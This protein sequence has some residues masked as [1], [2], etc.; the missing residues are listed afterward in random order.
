MQLTIES[1]PC[2]LKAFRER[3]G[4]SQK[5]VIDDEPRY[6]TLFRKAATP[7]KPRDINTWAEQ[8]VTLFE[9]P[10][11]DR[12]YK[13]SYA[14]FAAIVLETLATAAGK[15]SQI[16]VIGPAQSGKTLLVDGIYPAYRLMELKRD[17]AIGA[18]TV[19]YA[20]RVWDRKLGP[21]ILNTKYKKHLPKIGSGSK[22]G[23][24]ESLQFLHGPWLKLFGA[25]GGDEQRSGDTVPCVTITETDKMDMPGEVSREADPVTQIIAR[26]QAFGEQGL[27]ILECT[28]STEEGRI[29][30]EAVINGSDGRF[31]IKCPHCF[32]WICP[33]RDHFIVDKKAKNAQEAAKS[34]FYACNECGVEWDE[35]DRTEANQYPRLVHNGQPID[36]AGGKREPG[37]SVNKKG[38]VVGTDPLTWT[39]K[40]G[41]RWNWFHV[42]QEMVSMRQVA[43]EEWECANK[44]DETLQKANLEKKLCQFRWAIPYKDDMIEEF[45]I[46]VNQIL[47][48]IGDYEQGIIPPDTKAF[49]AAIDPGLYQCWWSAYAWRDEMKGFLTGCGFEGVAQDRKKDPLRM[50]PVLREMRDDILLNKDDGFSEMNGEPVFPDV[51]LVDAGYHPKI[52]NKFVKESN[53]IC[54]D[55]KLATRF[56]A[57]KGLGT[58]KNQDNWKEPKKGKDKI[59]REG[60]QLVKQNNGMGLVLLNTDYWKH[61]IHGG[62]KASEDVPGSLMLYDDE[63]NEHKEFA[64]HITAERYESKFKPGKGMI[65]Y[66][67]RLVKKNHLFDTSYMCMAAADVA[68]IRLILEEKPKELP[69]RKKR[70]KGKG[71]KIGR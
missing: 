18:P 19:N 12:K 40:C 53:E 46:S 7:E 38:E 60:W 13:A 23:K 33:D 10:R 49:T 64:R 41:I 48:K 68:G 25:G 50:L 32:Q 34:A 28:V 6:L 58:E 66:W 27:A 52:V 47:D 45:G 57:A 20:Q 22:K 43:A 16:A 51:V 63:R 56:F 61:Q 3:A 1:E 59:V 11:E 8:E 31:F 30:Q 39:K 37:Q 29:W 35:D 24:F 36:I 26:T 14:K 67:N 65:S 62:L 69:P 9:G 5:L 54:R 70:E 15:W 44:P 21:I 71:W 55:L 42:P 4:T 17:H 2:Y